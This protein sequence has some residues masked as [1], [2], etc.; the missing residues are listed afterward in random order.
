MKLSSFI[1]DIC[2]LFCKPA[3]AT[4]F[5]KPQFV[6]SLTIPSGYFQLLKAF[7]FSFLIACMT[8]NAE[9]MA[10]LW[11]TRICSRQGILCLGEVSLFFSLVDRFHQA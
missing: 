11:S 8:Y 6:G 7:F 5:S 3:A 10:V 1:T 2:N 4:Y 9:R